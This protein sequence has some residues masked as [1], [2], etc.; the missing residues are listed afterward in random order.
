[1]GILA[2]RAEQWFVPLLGF[3]VVVYFVNKLV[4]YARLR[5]FRGPRW[6][7]LTDLPHSKAMLH[8]CHEWYADVSDKYG[9]IA[10][11]APN[12]LVTSSPT[13]WAHV[14]NKPGYKRSDWYYH[15]CRVEYRRDNVFTQTDN[16]KHEQRRKQMAP[17]YSGRENL[18]LETSVDKRLQEFI[19]LIRSKYISCDDQ[20]LPMDLAKKVQ[21]FTLDVISTVGLGKPFGMLPSDRDVDDYVKSS[22]EGLVAASIALALGMS[23]M[24]QAPLI[25]KF[26]APSPNDNNGFGKMMA[27]CFRFVDERTANPVDKRSD[28]LASFIRHGLTGDELRSEA[29]E[30]II[31]GSDTTAGAIRG[32]LLQI[33][34]NPRVY[35]KL[36]R[37]VDDAVRDGKASSAADGLITMEQTKRLPYLQAV[38]RESLRIWP[39]V[40]NIFSRDVPPGGDTVNVNG[41]DVFLP[42]GTCIGHSSWAMHHSKETYGQDAKMFRP[43]RWFESDPDK[44]AEMTRTNDLVFG[45]G[46]FQCLGKPVAQ[47]EIGKLVFELMR[48]FELSLLNPM[49]PWVTR[50]VLGLFAISDM[51]IQV[52]ERTDLS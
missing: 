42:G 47:L 12:L 26:I 4:V 16:V 45:H 2:A 1:M 13:I 46:K 43:E 29:L 41:E 27:T 38:I 21:Y 31:A 14:N 5:Q 48:N 15:A 32:T 17:G 22:E 51:W 3:L 10:R 30:Q 23:W 37:E 33:M 28:M 36:Q 9:P 6:T 24:A 11:V 49:R 18:D 35:F 8:N 34:A 40:A 19:N 44:L 7:G 25:G 39:P 20:I 52:R 50:N